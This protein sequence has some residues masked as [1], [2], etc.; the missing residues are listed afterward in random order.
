MPSWSLVFLLRNLLHEGLLLLMCLGV[1]VSCSVEINS[2]WTFQVVSLWLLWLVIMGFETPGIVSEHIFL[3]SSHING[4]LPVV[5]E[6]YYRQ[7]SVWGILSVFIFPVLFLV[8][9]LR[10]YG[11]NLCRGPSRHFS[12]F[13]FLSG[14]LKLE[15]VQ[16]QELW[17]LVT[18][19]SAL[20]F[21]LP[22]S[23]SCNIHQHFSKTR[24][25]LQ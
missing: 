19:S 14:V 3:C 22:Y 17:L 13:E 10:G 6:C 7:H 1:Q 11:S 18:G 9:G 20:D 8:F 21:S 12:T 23:L 2:K 4:V 15:I 24:S 16:E 25:R 5:Q